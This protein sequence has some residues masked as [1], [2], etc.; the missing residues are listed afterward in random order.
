MVVDEAVG[1][2]CPFQDDIGALLPMKCEKTA[3][4]CLALGFKH[5]HFHR[6]A[7]IA[8]LLDTAPLHLG[9]GIDTAHDHSFHTFLNDQ[10]RTRGRLPVV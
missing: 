6:N 10:I 8:Q 4:Q 9:K 7:G 3:V 1:R 5:T 2:L